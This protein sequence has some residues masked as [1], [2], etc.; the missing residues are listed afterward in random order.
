MEGSQVSVI[1]EL[2]GKIDRLIRSFESIRDRNRE[3]EE[4]V[5]L[6]RERIREKDGEIAELTEKNKQL[7]L[8][9]ALITGGEDET[10]AKTN[11]NRIVREIDKC[12]ALLNR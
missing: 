5:S 8:S 12:I 11:V 10:E 9:R 4:E 2:R 6:L 3:L 1:Q 7:Q